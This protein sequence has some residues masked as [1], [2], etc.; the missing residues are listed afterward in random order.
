[1]TLFN[2]LWLHLT[3]FVSSEHGLSHLNNFY[4]FLSYASIFLLIISCLRLVVVNILIVVKISIFFNS[5]QLITGILAWF[6]STK[7]ILWEFFIH[8]RVK[9]LTH[10]CCNYNASADFE[11]SARKNICFK[12]IEREK[13]LNIT[14]QIFLCSFCSSFY[15]EKK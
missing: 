1:M 13:S 9:K 10:V 14:Q 15:N 2:T 5:M 6:F 4:G 7:K 11:F 8:S 12:Q 3:L